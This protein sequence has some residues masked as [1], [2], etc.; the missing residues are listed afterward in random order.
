MGAALT[1]SIEFMVT[2]QPIPSSRKLVQVA[3]TPVDAPVIAAAAN[4]IDDLLDDPKGLP[5][6]KHRRTHLSAS[7]REKFKSALID[8]VGHASGW[9]ALGPLPNRAKG[10]GRPPDN[11][12]FIFI[13][14][15]ACACEAVGLKP[16]R[17]YVSG[18]ESLPVQ[19]F[20]TLAPLLWGPM[21]APR[22]LFERWQKLRSTLTR[23]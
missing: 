4:R 7:D 8:A 10:R 2:K 20:L 22:K 21:K 9:A 11:A 1:Q 18:S 13:D 5:N 19:I 14:D 23:S 15:I 17:R 6:G 12:V 3:E 16:G